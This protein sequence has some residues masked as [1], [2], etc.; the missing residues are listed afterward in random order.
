M[1]VMVDASGYSDRGDDPFKPGDVVEGRYKV[2]RRLSAGGVGAVYEVEH[3]FTGMHVALKALHNQSGDNPERMRAEARTLAEMR[4][5]N[6]VQITDGGVTDRTVWFTMELL[7]GR[8]LREEILRAGPLSIARALRFGMQVAEGVAVAHAAGVIHRDLKPENIFVVAESDSIKILDFGTSKITSKQ[9]RSQMLK[10]TDRFRLIGTQAYMPPERLRA[11]LADARADV[12]AVGHML[13]E[14]IAG[15]HCWSEGPG[16]LDLPPPQELGLRQIYTIPRPLR[17]HAP[18]VPEFIEALVLTALAKDPDHR[19]QTMQEMAA[20]LR[21]ALER[22]KREHPVEPPRRVQTAAPAGETVEATTREQP[23]W[24]ASRPP[25][26]AFEDRAR[27]D[28]LLVCGAARFAAGSTEPDELEKGLKAT[29]LAEVADPARRGMLR[30]IAHA[31]AEANPK[32]RESVRRVICWIGR[33]EGPEHEQAL[34]QLVRSLE[35]RG[36]KPAGDRIEP[37]WHADLALGAVML[38]DPERRLD[39]AENALVRLRDLGDDVQS[40]AVSVM[41]A[42]ARTPAALHPAPRGALLA[43]LLGGPEDSELAHSELAQ[44]VLNAAAASG[45]AP[46]RVAAVPVAPRRPAATPMAPTVAS[47]PLAMAQPVRKASPPPAPAKIG[48][49]IGIGA[50]ASGLVLAGGFAM[51]SRANAPAAPEASAAEE[52]RAETPPPPIAS[53]V[54]TASVAEPRP[55]DSASSVVAPKPKET[56]PAADVPAARRA[57]RPTASATRLPAS[58]L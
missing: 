15:R 50:L 58:G 1:G 48:W 39:S 38:L 45:P 43:L 3:A 23:L 7:D 30:V 6:I 12:Y 52:E 32:W 24:V 33:S 2:I 35:K 49:V 37:L 20:A 19:Q 56:R 29:A 51:K 16:P 22:Y 21:S 28:A 11:G 31:S 46:P 40:L 14:M 10:T 36:W 41:V 13:Y 57:P 4:H 54:P 9:R 5:P 53:A 34:Q 25:Q 26:Q 27:I 47:P 55:S 44:F 42:F 18:D 8:T 17:E